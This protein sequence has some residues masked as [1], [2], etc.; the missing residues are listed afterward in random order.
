VLAHCRPQG[1]AVAYLCQGGACSAPVTTLD[2][3]LDALSGAS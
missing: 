3:L 1:D 2:G